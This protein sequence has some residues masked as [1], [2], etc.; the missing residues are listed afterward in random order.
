[1]TASSRSDRRTGPATPTTS[2]V[3]DRVNPYVEAA[4]PRTLPAAVAPVLVGTAAAEASLSAMSAGRFALALTVALALQVAVNYAN[5]YFDGVK[6]V[7][8]EARTGPRRAVASG[9]VA[10]SE[11]KRAIVVTL[12]VAV[13]AGGWLAVLVGPELVVVGVAAVLATL[14]Y[15][16]G[17]RP[18]ASAALGEVMVFVFF[19][20]VATVGSAYVQDERIT[21]LA[22]LASLPMGCLATAL[23]VVN[24]L[25]DIPSDREVGKRTLAVRLGAPATRSLYLALVAVAFLTMPAIL[26]AA[27]DAWLLLPLLSL[28]V[29]WPGLRLV[30]EAPLGPQLIAALAHTAQGQLVFA[31]LLTAGLLL[32]RPGAGP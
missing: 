16:G 8:T 30:R 15:S 3:R 20:V 10:P 2:D 9:L 27:G 29:V 32:S 19:G 5:D 31:V 14:G 17:S 18:Y 23:L 24:N 6:G 12:L 22:L 11:M 28:P 26:V 21:A 1:V 25:R 13:V 7:D 4:R